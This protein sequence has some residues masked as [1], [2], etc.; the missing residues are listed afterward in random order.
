VI[1]QLASSAGLLCLALMLLIAPGSMLFIWLSLL[2]GTFVALVDLLALRLGHHV[3]RYTSVLAAALLLGYC[4]GTINTLI[5]RWLYEEPLDPTQ[6]DLGVN[7]PLMSFS[8]AIAIV[9]ITSAVLRLLSRAE[10]ATFVAPF[11]APQIA[12][13]RSRAVMAAC[14]LIAAA[15]FAFG[16]LGY[17]GV[18]AD[19]GRNIS[20]IGAYAYVIGPAL[21]ALAVL[22]L[23]SERGFK[24]RAFWGLSL[25]GSIFG[26]M[27]LGRRVLIFAV[28]T[29]LIAGVF[30]GDRSL[31]GSRRRVLGTIVAF[32]IFGFAVVLGTQAFFALRLA[33][34]RIGD[35]ADLITA[36][37]LAF[38]ILDQD[39]AVLNVA[40]ADNIRDRTF[41]LS[42]LSAF[43]AA[44]ETYPPLM[45]E[46]LSF[47]VKLAVPSALFPRKTDFLPPAPEHFVHPAFGMPVFDGPDT[48][49]TAGFTDFGVAGAIGY[50]LVLAG[51]YAWVSRIG[52]SL[53]PSFLFYFL[54]AR[55][56]YQ[57][58]YVE[59]SL[60]SF[61]TVFL[62][63]LLV[64]L[65]FL[66]AI[67]RM[68][69]GRPMHADTAQPCR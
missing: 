20:A 42:F 26:L 69:P 65:M 58:F 39:T 68:C 44:Q 2:I 36:L 16:D 13:S 46:Q 9:L 5:T 43:V 50:V 6:N 3:Y 62:R 51:V 61:F 48:I 24:W 49:L 55:L 29:A 11:S 32:G 37:S 33:I 27:V 35:T 8:L 4:A 60:A 47:A 56:T 28:V 63:D 52:R 21:P 40:L 25:V 53:L 7:Y 66:F 64:V 22:G 19:Q 10:P 30:F 38:D 45:G 17:M 12:N 57:L 1:H 67:W 15:A 18:Q 34:E 54:W 59:D 23:L 31:F 41:I 14:L